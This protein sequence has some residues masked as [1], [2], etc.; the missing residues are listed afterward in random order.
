MDYVARDARCHGLDLPFTFTP[1][2]LVGNDQSTLET[3]LRGN[4]PATG[5]P[6][7]EEIIQA[8]TKSFPKSRQPVE[9]AKQRLPRLL[10]SDNEANLQRLFVENGWTDGLPIIL[11]TEER[12][13]EMLSGTSHDRDEVVGRMTITTNQEKLEYTVEK[14]AVNAVMAGARPEHLPVILA[15]ASIAEGSMPSSTTS[16]ARMVMVNGPIRNEIGMNSGI[17]ALSPFNLANSVIGRAWTLMT[18][19]LGDARLGE[20]FMGSQGNTTNYNNMCCAENEERSVWEPFHVEKGFKQEESVVSLFLGWS[21]VNSMGA[22]NRRAAHEE[23]AIILPAFPAHTSSATLIMDP[24]VAR[25]LKERHGFESK[26]HLARWLSENVK[27]PAKQYWSADLVYAFVLPL[28]EQGVEPFA[29][30]HKLPPNELIAHYNKPENINVIVV[31]GET[32]PLWQTTDFRY[33]RSASIDAWRPKNPIPAGLRMPRA[34][35]DLTCRGGACE[36]P[37]ASGR[38]RPDGPESGNGNSGAG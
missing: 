37:P 25:G 8:L 2:P 4:D 24:L 35:V 20:T 33:T 3:Y 18:I 19:N 30:W 29:S 28:A 14:V 36:L 27:I 32:N 16:F 23:T 17:G 5:V 38:I 10:S 31:G 22:P 34:P 7:L 13:A 9:T 15:I 26:R 12:V 21:V 1:H 6:I 11:P